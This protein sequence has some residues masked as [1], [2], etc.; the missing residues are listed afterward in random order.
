MED[1]SDLVCEYEHHF[2]RDIV[3]QLKEVGTWRAHFKAWIE[4]KNEGKMP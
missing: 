1:A 2:W 3:T 4:A